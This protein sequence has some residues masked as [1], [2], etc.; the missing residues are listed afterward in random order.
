MS[1]SSLYWK[2]QMVL[3]E[4]R[5][6]G[7]RGLSLGYFPLVISCCNR[8]NIMILLQHEITGCPQHTQRSLGLTARCVHLCASAQ[9]RH[10]EARTLPPRDSWP[11]RA[12]RTWRIPLVR[13]ALVQR[14]G[15]LGGVA[16]ALSKS[17]SLGASTRRLSRRG[18]PWYRRMAPATR[19]AEP[20]THYVHPSY[21]KANATRQRAPGEGTPSP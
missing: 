15:C 8:F 18:I 5:A 19:R 1:A 16:R 12:H 11:D 3:P 20:R 9:P 17:S 4:G 21:Q 14:R 13:C 2:M 7:S 6:S 10:R